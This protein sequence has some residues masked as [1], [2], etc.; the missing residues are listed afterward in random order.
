[1][2]TFKRVTYSDHV[3]VIPPVSPQHAKDVVPES[4]PLGI[5]KV[6]SLCR[7]HEEDA[8]SPAKHIVWSI[9]LCGNHT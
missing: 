3:P 6:L 2:R 7:E 5:S 9:S 1:M 8:F 4:G